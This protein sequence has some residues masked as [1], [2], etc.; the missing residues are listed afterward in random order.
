MCGS[1]RRVG[2]RWF[3]SLRFLFVFAV[4]AADRPSMA[5]GGN[6]LSASARPRGSSLSDLALG[7]SA[8]NVGDRNPADLPPIRF[9]VLWTPPGGD[10]NTFAVAP[11]T[12]F[13]DPLLDNWNH[14]AGAAIG[15]PPGFGF[16][17]EETYTLFVR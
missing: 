12:R 2:V 7:T 6:V 13:Y 15:G 5:R 10:S 9:Q 11:G 3:A 16:D 14:A 4:N 1:D 8:F 17:F